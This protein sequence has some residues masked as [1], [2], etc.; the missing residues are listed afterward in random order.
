MWTDL[1]RYSMSV[2]IGLSSYA[3][4]QKGD[5]ADIYVNKTAG[6]T[7]DWDKC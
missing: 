1:E 6:E 2:Q 7:G 5:M 3:A 4:V